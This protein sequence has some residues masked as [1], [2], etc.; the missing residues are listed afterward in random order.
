M[1]GKHVGKMMGALGGRIGSYKAGLT[2]G[3]VLG[4][5]IARNIFRD[6]EADGAQ[7]TAVEELFRTLKARI[8]AAPLPTLLAGRIA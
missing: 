8:D 7:V 5:A 4:P 6:P 2:D 3:G 1:V